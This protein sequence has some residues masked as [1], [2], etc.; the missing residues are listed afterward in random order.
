[1]GDDL[2]LEGSGLGETKRNL[3]GGQSRVAVDDG[4][5]L[6]LHLLN[7]EGVE[8]DDLLL[9]AV[10]LHSEGSLSDVGGEDLK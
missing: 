6:V 9:S 5:E 1:M 3:M 4:V 2:L 8:Q 7:I 10:S